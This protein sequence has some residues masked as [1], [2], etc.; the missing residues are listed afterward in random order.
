MVDELN[1]DY[2]R[3][4]R[5]KGM[6][7]KDIMVRHVLKNAFVPMIAYIPASVLLTTGGPLLVERFF[8]VP[9]MG[10]LLTDAIGRYDTSVVQAAVMAFVFFAVVVFTFIATAIGKYQYT[11]L[12]TRL[13]EK[14][15]SPNSEYWFGTDNLGRD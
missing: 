2:I 13:M 10:P 15:T 9:G 1:K 4:A 6:P 3:L 11:E 8:S 7:T 12:R 5:V 14:F